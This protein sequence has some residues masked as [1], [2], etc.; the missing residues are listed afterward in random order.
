MASARAPF[1]SWLVLKM[2]TRLRAQAK[3]YSR[4]AN[5]IAFRTVGMAT[6]ADRPPVAGLDSR[7]LR[8]AQILLASISES[9]RRIPLSPPSAHLSAPGKSDFSW[10]DIFLL[11]PASAADSSI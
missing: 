9:A 8:S 4:P 2:R 6:L 7:L 11:W 3:N 5:I 1:A 10:G